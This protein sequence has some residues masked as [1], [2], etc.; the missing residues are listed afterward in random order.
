MNPALIVAMSEKHA[1]MVADGLR[2]TFSLSRYA[3]E[4]NG[5]VSWRVV[6]TQHGWSKGS[7]EDSIRDMRNFALGFLRALKAHCAL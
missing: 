6:V 5:S 4:V 7:Q 2:D 3:V 1:E